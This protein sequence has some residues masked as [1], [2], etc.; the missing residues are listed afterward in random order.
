M[1]ASGARSGG[2]WPYLLA[3]GAFGLLGCSPT[4][5]LHAKVVSPAGLVLDPA[6]LFV[7][8]AKAC[9][10]GPLAAP[11]PADAAG[12]AEYVRA[13]AESGGIETT[14]AFRGREC[15]V[16]VTAWYDANGNAAVDTGDWVGSSPA[17]DVVDEGIFGENSARSPDVTLVQR[18]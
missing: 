1:P 5:L 4:C 10:P 12:D 14:A 13:R 15:R 11:P 9:P 8:G 18:T 17:V 16:L 7:T 2:R 6:R 3:L